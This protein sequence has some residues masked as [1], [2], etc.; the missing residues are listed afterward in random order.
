MIRRILHAAFIALIALGA[1]GSLSFRGAVASAQTDET[2]HIASSPFEAAGDAYYA[3]DQGFF[4]RNGL[5]TTT[6]VIPNGAATLAAI[7]GGSLQIGLGNTLNVAQA[8]VRGLKVS[9]VAP[10]YMYARDDP[11]S[12]EL[13]VAADSPIA[14]AAG[15]DGKTIMITS[16][17]SIDSIAVDS[18]MSSNGGDVSSV[19]Y[20]ESH[21][22]LMAAA[23]AGGRVDAAL[24]GNP[25]LGSALAGG[26]VRVLSRPYDAIG[27]RVMVTGYIATDE[28]AAKHPDEI[29]RF[30][31]AINQ[32]ATWAVKNPERAAAVLAK[33]LKIQMTRVHEF[34]P[35][36]L[37]PALI[38]PML[39]GAYRYK[40][41][42]RLVKA[43][44]IIWD[45]KGSSPST[46]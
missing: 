7:V 17:P 46:P 1:L 35:R 3:Q 23:V 18:W 12:S 21:P 32:A 20:V 37:D 39:D 44:E 11:A 25:A 43:E 6:Q 28:W 15:L 33:Y 42:P 19:K 2:I 22:D 38:Q 36:S 31:I 16:N 27:A 24:I 40:M 10:D 29:R 45:P 9:F 13:V 34:H 4:A 5:K 26:S 14:T 30:Q 41:T 8:R